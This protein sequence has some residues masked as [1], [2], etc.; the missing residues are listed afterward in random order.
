MMGG[1]VFGAETRSLGERQRCGSRIVHRAGL[2]PAALLLWR[3]WTDPRAADSR[4][5]C[6]RIPVFSLSIADLGRLVRRADAR[7]CRD[8]RSCCSRCS[9]EASFETGLL[10]DALADRDRNRR[11]RSPGGS[12]TE[13]RRDCL[14]ASGSRC[15]PPGCS[16]C[17]GSAATRDKFDIAW[18]MAVCGPGF[19]LFQS[20]NNRPI[21]SSAPQAAARGRPAECSRRQAARAD[22]GRRRV[23]AGF[24]VAGLKIAPGL[25]LSAGHRRA[26]AAA[27]GLLDCAAACASGAVDRCQETRL[28]AYWRRPRN[29]LRWHQRR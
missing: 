25:L 20:P 26:V 17:R 6:L 12:P 8:R 23:A 19:G 28:D 18:R 14:A 11:R 29:R 5:I 22:G 2:L 27:V 24:H 15:S 10:D 13:C 1:V 9:G 21:V 3:E 4:S 16:R 7:L